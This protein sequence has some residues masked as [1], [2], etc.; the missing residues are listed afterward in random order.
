MSHPDV[1]YRMSTDTDRSGDEDS[2]SPVNISLCL[3]EDGGL[4]IARDED[5]GVT[6]QGAT[7]QSALE[8]LD[9]AV[10]GYYGAG[11]AP[12]D[13][14]LQDLGIDPAENTSGSLDDSDVFE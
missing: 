2:T 13:E 4:W 5:T 12:T 1:D 8:N 10:A 11:E 7:R 14:Q 3:G 6:S 9:E